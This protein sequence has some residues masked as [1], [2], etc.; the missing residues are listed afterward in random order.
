MSHRAQGSIAGQHITRALIER[1]GG[2]KV[3]AGLGVLFVLLALWLSISA[4]WSLSNGTGVYAAEKSLYKYHSAKILEIN[5][6]HIV[7]ESRDTETGTAIVRGNSKSD[8]GVGWFVSVRTEKA[9]PSNVVRNVYTF[10]EFMAI[11]F[12]FVLGGG[13]IVFGVISTVKGWG[14]QPKRPPTR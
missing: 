5:D 7:I 13:F 14:V 2:G 3:L 1:F 12:V 10:G 9:N 11:A 8:D 6:G 4:I